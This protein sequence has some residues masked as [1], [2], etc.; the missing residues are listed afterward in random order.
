MATNEAAGKARRK[1]TAI[2]LFD[3]RAGPF[4]QLAVLHARRASGLARAAVEASV[5]MPDKRLAQRQPPFVHKHHLT[6]AP[7]RRIRFQA[8]QSVRGALVEAQA[9]VNAMQIIDVFG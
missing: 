5:D 3:L 1:W 8:P 9:A 2:I 6:D 4:H 7:A